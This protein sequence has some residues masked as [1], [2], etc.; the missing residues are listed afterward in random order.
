MDNDQLAQIISGIG[1]LK[2]NMIGSFAAEMI[3]EFLPADSFFICNNESSKRPGSPWVMVAKKIGIVY[4]GDSPVIDLMFCRNKD[5]KRFDVLKIL[6]RVHLQKE[7][8][9]GLHCVY[10]EFSLFSKFRLY[11]VDDVFILRFFAKTL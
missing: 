1:V 9:C 11:N 8:L 5:L 6:N 7:P 10:F 4:F 2:Q 3:P